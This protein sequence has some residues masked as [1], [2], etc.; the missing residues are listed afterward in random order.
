[1][2]RSGNGQ[3]LRWKLGSIPF[4]PAP[5]I[6]WRLHLSYVA[7]GITPV[8]AARSRSKPEERTMFFHCQSEEV[9]K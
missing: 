4:C 9:I 2:G 8:I 3:S 7:T 5:G 6:S 1:M